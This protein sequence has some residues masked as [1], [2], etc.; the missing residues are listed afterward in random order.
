MLDEE[1]IKKNLN[2]TLEETDF[3]GLGTKYRGKVRDNYVKDGKRIIITTDRISAFDRVLTTLPFK[4]Q[5]LNQLSAFWFEKTKDIVPNA[6]LDQPDP[7][8]TVFRECKVYPVEMVVRRYLAGS[9]WRDYSAGKPISGIKL[10]EG[11]KKGQKLAEPIVTPSTKADTGH[12]EHISKEEIIAK[13]IVLKETYEQME[14]AALAL[15]KE[16]S[17]WCLKQGLILVDTKYEF[18][19]DNGKL[20][21]VDEMH[22]PDSSRFWYV[23]SYDELFKAGKEQRMLDKEYVRIWLIE[24]GFMGDGAIPKIPDGVKI[25]AVSK[26]NKAYEQ[27]TGKKLEISSGKIIERI[28]KALQK[29]G[30]L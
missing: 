3:P 21:V 30:Y 20:V 29:K 5:I 8:V 16:G 27:I 13:G 17:E 14:K 26:Y 18:A 28:K 7:N 23:D 1:T 11:M 19:D 9:A 24:Q 2:N 12:D 25:E 6:V 10:A 4:G 22:T 15:F